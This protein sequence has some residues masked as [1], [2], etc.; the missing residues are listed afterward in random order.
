MHAY[1]QMTLQ[2]Q[3]YQKMI[4]KDRCSYIMVIRNE[5][6]YLSVSYDYGLIAGYIYFRVT[7]LVKTYVYY[8]FVELQLLYS[9]IFKK[10]EFIVF[11]HLFMMLMLFIC[12]FIYLFIYFYSIYLLESYIN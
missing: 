2:S 6:T 8:K 12:L 11:I 5:K 3:L 9:Y 4:V 7:A 10:I 1:I